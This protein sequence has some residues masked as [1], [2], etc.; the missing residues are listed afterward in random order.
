MGSLLFSCGGLWGV[1][2]NRADVVYCL[3]NLETASTY[4]FRLEDNDITCFTHQT[5][6]RVNLHYA[7]PQVS[8]DN[9]SDWVKSGVILETKTTK[10]LKLL[11][12]RAASHVAC[13]PP[14]EH[15]PHLQTW[16]LPLCCRS[17]QQSRNYR[18][19]HLRYCNVPLVITFHVTQKCSNGLILKHLVVIFFY[20]RSVASLFQTG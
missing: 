18:V 9:M 3:K 17:V 7:W 19:V 16:E 8:S 1:Y 15:V 6:I 4:Y 12:H 10:K 5:S 13:M 2:V 11:P 20:C 14:A